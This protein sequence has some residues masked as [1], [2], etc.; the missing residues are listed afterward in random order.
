MEVLIMI[1]LY[2]I[3]EDYLAYID[4]QLSK[5]RNK[6]PDC[7]IRVVIKNR[8]S[9]LVGT[10]EVTFLIIQVSSNALINGQQLI[11]HLQYTEKGNII[12]PYVNLPESM[13]SQWYNVPIVCEHCGVNRNRKHSFIVR[14]VATN[15]YRQIGDSCVN[16]YTRGDS[17]AAARAIERFLGLFTPEKLE[18]L[19][20]REPMP[21]YLYK[22]LIA[23]IISG[24]CYKAGLYDDLSDKAKKFIDDMHVWVNSLDSSNV[25][26]HNYQ[27][28]IKTVFIHKDFVDDL[29]KM[30]ND[31]KYFLDAPRRQAEAEAKKK[32]RERRAYE[33]G[34]AQHKLAI[35][36]Y[37]NDLERILKEN[38][39]YIEAYKNNQE[40]LNTNLNEVSHTSK[41]LGEVGEKVEVTICSVVLKYKNPSDFGGH[42]GIYIFETLDGDVIQWGTTVEK[43][44]D[45]YNFPSVVDEP[46]SVG[47]ILKGTIKSLKERDGNE[48]T[49]LT[50]CRL[51]ATVVPKKVDTYDS[52]LISQ[53]QM[54]YRTLANYKLGC[55]FAD[56][57]KDYDVY[58]EEL[59]KQRERDLKSVS[60]DRL[61]ESVEL[62]IV[63]IREFYDGYSTAYL[64]RCSDNNLYK[65]YY[66]FYILRKL[67]IVLPDKVDIEVPVSQ[68]CKFKGTLKSSHVYDGIKYT[69]VAYPKIL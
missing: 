44:V 27:T 3:R 48:T 13:Y 35:G 61:G 60:S 1:G 51:K 32:E 9:E 37:R 43:V 54:G 64:V 12:T 36:V 17:V 66:D 26:N 42:Y 6:Y 57:L 22:D 21:L 15:T 11:A 63:S 24:K 49:C 33:E 69:W 30:I 7:N 59:K 50:N 67:C 25:K 47:F 4:E 58:L 2:K 38:S 28:L 39:K 46:K 23:S 18:A 31:Y 55:Q 68:K 19:Y 16:K 52:A 53:V 41:R 40:L 14:D 65:F 29:R 8:F 45:K 5:L 56:K 62:T 34:K 20:Q 10:K